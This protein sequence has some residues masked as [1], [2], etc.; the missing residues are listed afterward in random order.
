VQTTTPTQQAP[1]TIPQP[2]AETPQTT[3]PTQQAPK[4]IEQKPIDLKSIQTVEDWKKNT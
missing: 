4:P 2:I 1:V 3:Q